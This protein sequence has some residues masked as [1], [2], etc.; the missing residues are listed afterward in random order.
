MPRRP[1]IAAKHDAPIAIAARSGK[2]KPPLEKHVQKAVIDLFKRVGCKVYTTSQYRASHVSVGFPDLYVRHPA[3][4]QCWWFETKTYEA[5][6]WQPYRRDTWRPKPLSPAQ[7]TFREEAVACGEHHYWGGE[8]EAEACLIE[9][10]LASRN[11]LALA[12][13]PMGI[14]APRPG[15]DGGGSSM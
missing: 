7:V 6:G 3:T 10:G 2:L 15:G 5:A 12:L 13:H 8:P 11:G 9:L 4:R 14:R 1:N